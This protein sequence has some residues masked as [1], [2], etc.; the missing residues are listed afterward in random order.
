MG[1]GDKNSFMGTKSAYVFQR[2]GVPAQA[3]MTVQDCLDAN[4]SFW[5]KDF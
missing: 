4:I 1:F 3:A 2:N 5:L